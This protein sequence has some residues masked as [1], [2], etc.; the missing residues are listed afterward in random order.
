MPFGVARA[1]IRQPTELFQQGAR[2]LHPPII[3]LSNASALYWQ[4]FISHFMFFVCAFTKA[5]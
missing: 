3:A 1:W 2:F 4:L 5:A